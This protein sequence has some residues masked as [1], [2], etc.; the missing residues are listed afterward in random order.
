M[1]KITRLFI[2]AAIM[3]AWGS[4][5]SELNA[6]AYCQAP[7]TATD[8]VTTVKLSCQLIS[9]GNYQI[10]VESDV[11]MTNFAAGVYCNING[12]GGNQVI[13]LPGY[14]RSSDGKTITVNIP[15]SSAPNLYTPLYILMPGEKNFAWPTGITW[16]TCVAQTDFT[17]P[18]MGTA[19]LVGSPTYNSANVTF[20]G[21]DD[22]TSPV[23]NY[24]LSDAANSITN[25][26]VAVDASGN[27]TI[28]GL[29]PATTYNFTVKARDAAF[30]ISANSASLQLT[31]VARPSECSGDRGHFGN[32]TV[33]KIHYTIQ[34]IGSNVIYTVTPFDAVAR[35]ISMCE[36][37]TT[38]GNNAM[39]IAADGKSAT[40]TK[41]GL[42][43]GTNVG[44][45]FMYK[46]DNMPG[47]EMTAD[48]SALTNANV[49]Y[50]KVGECAISDT[51][52]PTAFTA[53]KGTVGA[54]SV[55]LLLNATDNLGIIAYTVS[56]GSGPTIV[57]QNGTSGVQKSFIVSG[58]DPSTEYTFS[59]VAKDAAGNSATNSETIIATTT[60]FAAAP[61]PTVDASKVISI[62]SDTY[63]TTPNSRQDWYGNNFS[64]LTLADNNSIT[65]NSSIC[66]FGYEFTAKPINVSAMNK[67]HVD[68]YPETLASMSLGITDGADRMKNGITL[69]ANQWNSVNLTLSE[70]T[71]ANLATVNQVGF[72]NLNGTFY[73]DNLYFYNDTP[74]GLTSASVENGI[75]CYPNPVTDQLTI[76]A[77][78]EI[79]QVIVRN[80]LGQ[81]V[82][83]VSVNGL[84]KSIDVSAISAGN[85]FVSIKLANGQSATQKFVKL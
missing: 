36:V 45:L 43:A 28:T 78:S 79:S 35:T 77:K 72:W 18:V 82:K 65:K 8:G 4:N 34:Y 7:I 31:T 9:A 73:L 30:N 58:L 63:T 61:T 13:A 17:L 70:L 50:Y 19:T 2:L 38:A 29:N 15:S 68:I 56:Y 85:Y 66:C 44:V 21:T 12:V 39:T 1:K 75:S 48:N 76:N 5:V 54:M 26:V 14:V 41:T 52:A 23:T 62:F 46:L 51:Q 3:L 27:G 57:T 59:I 67:L 20:T 83:T 40:Y 11:A 71:G 24:V 16:G 47:N 64:M 33:K 53:T 69:I 22:V 6:A 32:P 84:E 60:A 81:T 37:Q 25:K 49:I 74:T 80:L 10:K 42:T 55:E